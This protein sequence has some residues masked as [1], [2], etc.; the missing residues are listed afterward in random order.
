M[1]EHDGGALKRASNLT[2]RRLIRAGAQIGW[3]EPDLNAE[4]RRRFSRNSIF[5]LTTAQALEFIRVL[6]A[7]G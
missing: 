6:F 3:S 7:R 5:Q 2:L 1:S 4:A